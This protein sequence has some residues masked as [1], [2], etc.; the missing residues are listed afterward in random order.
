MV[1]CNRI[2]G[3]F[4]PLNQRGVARVFR[5][6][7]TNNWRIAKPDHLSLAKPGGGFR[8]AIGNRGAVIEDDWG[9]GA[10]SL[11]K[12]IER[13]VPAAWRNDRGLALPLHKVRSS[14]MEPAAAALVK[15]MAQTPK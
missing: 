14:V 8:L 12:Q 4:N 6:S 15:H 13:A 2:C 9:N 1:D 3:V 11:L 5:P 7:D 10:I